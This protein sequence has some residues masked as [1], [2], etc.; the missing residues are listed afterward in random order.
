M[1][2]TTPLPWQTETWNR[3]WRANGKGR[4]PHALLL[5]GQTGLGKSRFARAFAQAL[6]CE[7]GGDGA[8]G[9]CRPCRQFA[10]DTSPDC[11][12]LEPP[13]K[14][15]T[16]IVDQVRELIDS[17]ALTSHGA[18]PRVAIIDPADALNTSAANSLLKTLEEP[19]GA[20]VLILVSAR[21]ARLP[22]TVRS[23]CRQVKFVPPP[24]AVAL[25]WLASQDV[26][27]SRA[28]RLLDLAGRRPLKALALNNETDSARGQSVPQ[29]ATDIVLGKR[30]PVAVAGGWSKEPLGELLELLI[31]WTSASTRS[32]F[33][34]ADSDPV[35]E[36]LGPK[37]LFA[38][39]DRLYEAEKLR[40]TSVN[41]QL[42]LEFILAPLAPGVRRWPM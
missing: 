42:L 13:E 2:D 12:L 8:C 40:D 21:P 23:R 14:K 41:Q 17:L 4:L 11:F 15:K 18:G 5:H 10:A 7:R 26:D 6:L 22:A 30:N 34:A 39:L 37:R 1:T 33:N 9:E 16:I 19:P 38:M 25:E 20:S 35:A 29:A 27:E 32:C 28:S 36:R 3:L 31:S 24:E